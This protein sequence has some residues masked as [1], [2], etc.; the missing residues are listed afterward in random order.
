M[1]AKSFP[2]PERF[3]QRMQEQL[4]AEYPDFIQALHK[5]PSTSFRLNPGKPS[6]PFRAPRIGQRPVPWCAE[7]RYLARRPLFAADPLIFAGAYYVQEASSMFLAH[8]LRSA[9]PANPVRALDLCAAPGGKSTLIRDC[10]PEGSL[11]VSNEIM[12]KRLVA[13]AENLTRWGHPD[14]V[15]TNNSPEDFRPLEDYF[16]VMVVDAPCSGEGMFRK[17]RKAVQMWSDMLVKACQ[18]RQ[19]QILDSVIGALRPGGLLV[20]STCTFAT[21]ENEENV[22][23]LA[24]SGDFEPVQ[25]P[26]G[27]EWGIT[28]SAI[29][30]NAGMFEGYRFYPHKARG[31]GFFLSCLRKKEDGYRV[32]KLRPP[33]RPLFPP[34]VSER[35]PNR[36]YALLVPY[37][38][39][40]QP[41]EF[42]LHEQ[43]NVW[44]IPIRWVEDF[45]LLAATL[46]LKQAGTEA[47]KFKNGKFIPGHGL[48]MSQLLGPEIPRLEL[49]YEQALAYLRRQDFQLPEDRQKADWQVVCW[50]GVPLGWI[51]VLPNRFNNYYPMDLRLRK[52]F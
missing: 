5:R 20:Y 39:P 51:K 33:K 14:V 2:L 49:D 19:V 9:M 40:G 4:G 10:L 31:E 16:D 43:E 30:T 35:L 21:E 26:I 23:R 18:R 44:A 6:Q 13:L 29:Q 12:P 52:Q 8:A 42:F 38:R 41:C 25:L 50:Q 47:G 46:R 28:T 37:L 32:R 3:L 15:V 48:A 22:R 11:L 36:H 34:A 27:P 45:K 7:G 1:R 24:E 17:D